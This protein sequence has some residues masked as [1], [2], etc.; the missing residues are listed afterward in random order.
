MN[1][2]PRKEFVSRR[3]LLIGG[4]I[5]LLA[6]AI[7]WWQ[8]NGPQSK[9]ADSPSTEFSAQR[10]ILV[11]KDL[12]GDEAPHPGGSEKNAA[13]RVRLIAELEKLG[14]VVEQVA[15][16]GRE[17]DGG[18]EIESATSLV[19][20]VARYPGGDDDLRP[21]CVATHYDSCPFGPGAGDAGSCLAALLETIRVLRAREFEPRRPVYFLFTDGE[22]YGMV[23]ARHFAR[24]QHTLAVRQPLVLNFDARGASGASLMYETHLDNLGA[25]ETA[26]PNLPWPRATGSSFVTIYRMLPNNTDFTEFRL[27]GWQ[28]LNFA[29]IGSPEVYHRPD[30]TIANLS[31]RSVQHHGE[32]ALALIE[33]LGR[34]TFDQFETAGGD[35]VFFDV[36][37]TIVVRYP[38]R[39]ALPLS[40]FVCALVITTS[41]PWLDPTRAIRAALGLSAVIASGVTI[42]AVAGYAMSVVI[43]ESDWLSRGV[44]FHSY[45][46]WFYLLFAL[47]GLGATLPLAASALR[48][49]ST[50]ELWNGVWIG[51]SLLAIGASGWLPGCSYALAVPALAAAV[52]GVLRVDRARATLIATALHAV[53]MAPFLYLLPIALGPGAG[54][55]VTSLFGL[56]G[57]SLYPLFG[58]APDFATR[59]KPPSSASHNLVEQ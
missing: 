12:L 17:T 27:A 55:V 52:A 1:Q 30:D 56:A 15:A 25:V 39:W 33:A 26:A 48:R 20:L 49:F 9:G 19:N 21:L 5:W 47:V 6:Y 11:L 54:V 32:N 53:V 43:R 3:H 40:I 59:I 35:A 36:L 28:G 18:R 42:A 38:A 45:D 4:A 8:Y 51:W 24:S 46:P 13:V 37:G 2:V 22:E 50:E 23:G 10:G 7:A 16:L 44:R 34:S 31:P 57:V 29:L 14:L 41:R 58:T